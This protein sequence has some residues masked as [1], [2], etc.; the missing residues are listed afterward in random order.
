M[1]I[2]IQS[3]TLLARESKFGQGFSLHLSTDHLCSFVE[4]LGYQKLAF[5]TWTVDGVIGGYRRQF[6]KNLTFTTVR[7]AGHMVAADK[8][9]AALKVLNEFLLGD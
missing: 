4:K 2:W 1:A 9:A 8:P 7:G 3:A 5:D 6:E